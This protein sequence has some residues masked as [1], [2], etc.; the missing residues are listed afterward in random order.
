[1]ENEHLKLLVEELAN[2]VGGEIEE[3][4]EALILKIAASR[5]LETLAEAKNFP[6][7]PCDFLHDLCGLDMG[8][9]FLVVY[10][11]SSL[12]GTQS[13]RLK[14]VV[15]RDDPVINSVTGLWP[16][17]DYLE[18]EAFDLFGIEFLGHPNLTRI[19]LWEGFEGFPLRKDYV[20][21]PAEVRDT[22]RWQRKGE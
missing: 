8:D 22:V 21:E 16:G 12:R 15:D 4:E 19:Y 13:L 17:A 20:T 9:H 14:A 11:L 3:S 6:E 1:M 18:R 7:V 2:R 10:Q 5:V